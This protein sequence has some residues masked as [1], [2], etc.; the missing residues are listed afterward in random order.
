MDCFN[1]SPDLNFIL[2][3]E[4]EPH[5]LNGTRYTVYEIYS[6]TTYSL[7]VN[8]SA[9]DEVE[10][11][12]V[13]WSPELSLAPLQSFS[14]A[15]SSSSSLTTNNK[16]KALP[17]S[18]PRA[19]EKSKISQAIAFVNDYDIYYK[20]KVHTEVVI[21]ITNSGKFD[22]NINLELLCCWGLGGWNHPHS[23]ISKPVKPISVPFDD[24]NS[25]KINWHSKF[26]IENIPQ[27]RCG[28]P[29]T[30]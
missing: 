29:S 26:D 18:R 1:I 20:P 3:Y 7:S 23:K 6:S 8:E 12:K 22:F 27:T 30:N 10:L 24:E 4:C 15:N 16:Y 2:L 21:R 14:S 9:N 13:L 11:Q 28:L 25:G 17:S 19:T 5:S